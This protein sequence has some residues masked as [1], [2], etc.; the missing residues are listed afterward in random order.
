MLQFFDNGLDQRALDAAISQGQVDRL[1][2]ALRQQAVNPALA[3]RTLAAFF[4]ARGNPL[5]PPL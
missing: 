2:S 3:R 5:G 4:Q 1:A